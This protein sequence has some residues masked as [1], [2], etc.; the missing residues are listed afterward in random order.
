M[1]LRIQITP[2][3]PCR[4]YKTDVLDINVLYKIPTCKPCHF[5]NPSSFKISLTPVAA[6]RDVWEKSPARFVI[7]SYASHPR[8]GPLLDNHHRR[9]GVVVHL[10]QG[11]KFERLME[12]KVVCL[13]L[14]Y[15]DNVVCKCRLISRGKKQTVFRFM[16]GT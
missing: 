13:S 7:D 10:I 16:Q 15:L 14:H 11:F 2:G 12:I 6:Q 8:K 9:V 1:E 5:W 3:T 4:L